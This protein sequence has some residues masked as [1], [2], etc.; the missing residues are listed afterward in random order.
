M[1]TV[2]S[3]SPHVGDFCWLAWGSLHPRSLLQFLMSGTK[4][5]VY[6]KPLKGHMSR[7]SGW[8]I[9]VPQFENHCPSCLHHTCL[10]TI[11]NCFDT[12]FCGRLYLYPPSLALRELC[13]SQDKGESRISDLTQDVFIDFTYSA[14]DFS[15]F[16][17]KSEGEALSHISWLLYRYLHM[18][19]KFD[20]KFWSVLRMPS[21]SLNFLIG[22]GFK[23]QI[24][25]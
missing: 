1:I 15:L 5:Y 14:S 4:S 9:A 19:R 2:L 25:T 3:V 11:S 22:R 21:L 12:I 23:K 17:M 20:T 16:V 24:T 8:G 6:P 18:L 10:I 13:W 7:S